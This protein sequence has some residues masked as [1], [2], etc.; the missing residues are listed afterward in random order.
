MVLGE[1]EHLLARFL[2]G[3]LSVIEH[4]ENMDDDVVIID[5]DDTLCYAIESANTACLVSRSDTNEAMRSI[6]GEEKDT[7]PLLIV[8]PGTSAF[9]HWCYL[10]QEMHNQE[11]LR[12]H[13]LLPP[14]PY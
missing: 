13:Q 10:Q 7:R 6:M 14:L 2:H 9:L 5:P 1:D 3:L 4:Q 11:P 8:V 12:R